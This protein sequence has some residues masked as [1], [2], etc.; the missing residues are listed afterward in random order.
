ML[1]LKFWRHCYRARGTGIGTV[2]VSFGTRRVVCRND[3][4]DTRRAVVGCRAAGRAVDGRSELFASRYLLA[5]HSATHRMSTARACAERPEAAA[6]SSTIWCRPARHD[7]LS[8]TTSWRCWQ[9]P[10][11]RH[12][13]SS[14]LDAVIGSTLCPNKSVYLFIFWITLSKVNRF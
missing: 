10:H 13:T 4:V 11:H 2:C 14:A 3:G 8:T 1:V 12:V 7:D 5:R 9:L 6:S